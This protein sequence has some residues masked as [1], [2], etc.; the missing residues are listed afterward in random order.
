[1]FFRP[2][3]SSGV[4][5]LSLVAA[6]EPAGI[7]EPQS[8]G[9]IC[10]RRMHPLD[11]SATDVASW[12]ALA[13][14]AIEPNVFL[15]PEFVQ[16]LL[17]EMKTDRQP[18][19]LIA[20]DLR[21]GEWLGLSLFEVSPWSIFSPFPVATGLV[22]P[23]VFQHGWL[24]SCR[25]ARRAIGALFRHQLEQR[26]W[27]GFHFK[28]LPIGSIQTYLMEAVARQ[29]GISLT[30]SCRW[31]RAEYVVRRNQTVDDLLQGC[32]K[33]RRKSLKRCRR[34]LE[35]L[36][37]VEYSLTPA[38][39]RNDSLV[40]EFLRLEM[41][42]WKFKEGTAIG[43]RAADERFFRGMIE[44]LSLNEEVLFGELRLDG[45]PIASTCNL[46]SG[47]TLVGFK[48]GWDPAFSAGAPGLWSEIELASSVSRHYPGI[49]RID[50]CAISGSYV[51]SVWPDRQPMCSGTFSWSRRG[52]ALQ[53]AKI[54]YREIRRRCRPAASDALK[55]ENSEEHS[56]AG[57]TVADEAAVHVR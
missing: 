5:E 3:I 18:Y 7:S 19:L 20:E 44:R 33:S 16:P 9:P 28:N 32:S 41:L 51:E 55:S 40:D 11:T 42:G 15:S 54:C 10:I 8:V 23:Y 36:G 52:K 34:H 22:S 6:P 39:G 35:G 37:E 56:A 30:I 46:R 57:T 24:I 14:N 47:S 38:H 50:S 27:H 17:R 21:A 43:L 29:L 26:Q 13:S 12:R 49:D 2:T 48:I 4:G 25:H 1:M 53:A 45:R 31:E